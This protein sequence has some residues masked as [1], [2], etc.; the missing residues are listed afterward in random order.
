MTNEESQPPSSPDVS[1]RSTRVNAAAMDGS[2][3]WRNPGW[4]VLA[5]AAA[6][7][8]AMGLIAIAI[9]LL[10]VSPPQG[11]R[12]DGVGVA[13]F[14]VF[15]ILVVPLEEWLTRGVLLQRHIK[16]LGAVGALLVSSAVFAFLH[17]W[18]FPAWVFRFVGGLVLGAFYLRTGS[19]WPSIVLHYM[20][21]LSSYA[22]MYLLTPS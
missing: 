20:Y 14:V 12:P 22:V 17:R 18:G 4:R 19:L 7:G 13:G 1:S 6:V 21:N 5:L 8:T 11:G 3:R 16:P 10:H 15:L 9:V 2:G